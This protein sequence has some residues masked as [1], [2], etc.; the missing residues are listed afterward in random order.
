M[1]DGRKFNRAKLEEVAREQGVKFGPDDSDSSIFD[2]LFE[3]K[4]L[5]EYHNPV[6]AMDYPTAV[7]PFA[8][9]KPGDR[10]PLSMA[11]I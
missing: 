8:K 9:T 5:A 11:S 2:E 10:I 6:I 3:G 4:L 7:S 1:L